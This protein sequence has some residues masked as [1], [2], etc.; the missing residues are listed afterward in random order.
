[1]ASWLLPPPTDWTTLPFPSRENLKNIPSPLFPWCPMDFDRLFLSIP[2]P[3]HNPLQLPANIQPLQQR[4]QTIFSNPVRSQI[5]IL[6][7][8]PAMSSARPTWLQNTAH[9]NM[10]GEWAGA[11]SIARWP[12]PTVLTLT[13]VREQQRPLTNGNSL[14]RHLCSSQRGSLGKECSQH[15]RKCNLQAF[16]I[17]P[18]P[19][20]AH[21]CSNP[22]GSQRIHTFSPPIPKEAREG[23]LSLLLC[24]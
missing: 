12:L 10:W 4:I 8:S 15:W 3:K 5:D 11:S 16:L 19:K 6:L 2:A 24:Q 21:H 14:E 13:I 20:V 9:K 7:S 23:D 22:I 18:A 17:G 1:M